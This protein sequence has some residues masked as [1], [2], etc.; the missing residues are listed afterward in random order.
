MAQV[1]ISRERLVEGARES[2]RQIEVA[3]EIISRLQEVID[4]EQHSIYS[5]RSRLRAIL[6]RAG[7]PLPSDPGRYES[8]AQKFVDEAGR[9]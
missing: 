6:E 5:A 3:E 1:E 9:E 8:A 7:V 2:L 4:Q